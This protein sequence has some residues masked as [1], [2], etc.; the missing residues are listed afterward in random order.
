MFFITLFII[1]SFLIGLLSANYLI[2]RYSINE[3]NKVEITFYLGTSVITSEINQDKEFTLI[4]PDKFHENLDSSVFVNNAIIPY[5]LQVFEASE[6]SDTLK[7]FMKDSQKQDFSYFVPNNRSLT[8][9][10]KEMWLK[11]GVSFAFSFTEPKFNVINH[12]INNSIIQEPIYGFSKTN[13]NMGSLSIGC[14]PPN[15]T[16]NTLFAQCSIEH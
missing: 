1:V 12:L 14:L 7:F 16:S 13:Q 8:K 10:N 15:I 5:N 2:T 9:E 4:S 11:F 3:Y 6:F